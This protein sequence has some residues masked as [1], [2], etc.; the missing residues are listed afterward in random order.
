[1]S[2]GTRS[3][4]MSRI[5]GRDTK[6]E[7]VL[8]QALWSAGLRG[9]RTHGALPGRPDIVVTRA[10][11][12]VFVDGCFWHSCPKC[13]IPAP[14]SRTDYWRPKLRRNK[15]RDQRVG[16][17]LRRIGWTSLRLWEH[18]V[19]RDCVRS[20]ARVLAAGTRLEVSRP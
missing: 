6:A 19:Q 9:Y 13:R 18:E 16:R 4:V 20:A 2:A 14:A 1:Y 3:Y 15:R 10:R 5:R 12:A 11:L 17:E 7:V 8:R